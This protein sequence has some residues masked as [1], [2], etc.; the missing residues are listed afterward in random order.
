[1]LDVE[2]E[3]L[4][5]IPAELSGRAHEAAGASALVEDAR[6]SLRHVRASVTGQRSRAVTAATDRLA[7][8]D[9]RLLACATVLDGAATLL[10]R[11]AEELAG[12]QVD[13]RQAL[14]DRGTA[15]A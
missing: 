13:A 9:E 6:S 10:H 2:L 15:V 14:A 3:P 4:A 7:S 5:G 8:V 11:H 1:M 12:L